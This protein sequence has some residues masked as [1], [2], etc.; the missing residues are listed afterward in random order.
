MS[1]AQGEFLTGKLLL[2]MPSI[3]D[4][5]FHHA[6]ILICEH[7]DN[8]AM[9]LMLNKPHEQ[10]SLDKF[11]GD[12]G[13]HDG[14]KIDIA[15]PNFKMFNGGPLNKERAILLHSND[16]KDD[17]TIVVNDDFSISGTLEF[18]VK[19]LKDDAARSIRFVL[20]SAGWSA[21]QLEYEMQD[22]AWLVT[23]ATPEIV[24]NTAPEDQWHAAL[25]QLGITPELLTGAAGRA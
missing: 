13:M 4:I 23:D 25:K 16:Y 7:D 22:N 2:A 12:L 24:F 6:V 3:G 9:G 18:L 17:D 21:G 5:R 15:D 10:L 20:G 1:S 11:L 19:I 14:I 8:G